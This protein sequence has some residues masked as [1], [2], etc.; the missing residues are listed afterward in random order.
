MVRESSLAL[1]FVNEGTLARSGHNFVRFDET[2]AAVALVSSHHFTAI[3]WRRGEAL[4]LM[5]ALPKQVASLL[6]WVQY[7]VRGPFPLARAIPTSGVGGCIR[8]G[9]RFRMP[10]LTEE[11]GGCVKLECSCNHVALLKH[12]EWGWRP[13][14]SGRGSNRGSLGGRKASITTSSSGKRPVLGGRSNG[15]MAYH[16][17]NLRR[18]A[19]SEGFVVVLVS[20]GSGVSALGGRSES[21][22]LVNSVVS[23]SHYAW[24]QG[25]LITMQWSPGPSSKRFAGVRKRGPTAA[26]D[27][28]QPPPD[29][30]GDG[31]RST[32][33]VDD[34]LAAQD[35]RRSGSGN[36]KEGER[37]DDEG[38][39]G[40]EPGEHSG[41]HDEQQHDSA[42]EHF[43]RDKQAFEDFIH[44]LGDDAGQDRLLDWIADKTAAARARREPPPPSATDVVKKTVSEPPAAKA[45]PRAL[46]KIDFVESSNGPAFFSQTI[47]APDALVTLLLS[48]RHLPLTVCTTSAINDVLNNLESVKYVKQFNRRNE[49]RELIDISAWPSESTISKEDWR[50]AYRNFAIILRAAASDAVCNLFDE[51]LAFLC[52]RPEFKLSFPAILKFDIEVRKNFFLGDGVKHQTRTPA[53][54]VIL[55]GTTTTCENPTSRKTL[56][57][58]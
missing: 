42:E 15:P 54:T 25:M 55:G 39:K 49:R 16:G 6:Y 33:E 18:S 22:I 46:S 5:R 31:S 41:A 34:T 8:L 12:R 27:K 4:S 9:G 26:S 21:R 48:K 56:R 7:G 11:G 36:G 2:H 44:E 51:H 52:A 19:T 53:A 35:G 47:V 20:D 10:M 3:G 13:I 38:E 17:S 57:S 23:K 30:N 29:E 37:R 50:D 1:F 32:G 58:R 40:D 14:N 24:I 28:I 43:E 45:A